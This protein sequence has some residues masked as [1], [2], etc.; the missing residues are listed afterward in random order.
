MLRELLEALEALYVSLSSLNIG[1]PLHWHVLHVSLHRHM[2][3]IH[4]VHI[5]KLT[6]KFWILIILTVILWLLIIG[7]K[8]ETVYVPEDLILADAS[9]LTYSENIIEVFSWNPI[10]KMNFDY[11]EEQL[12][13]QQCIGACLMLNSMPHNFHFVPKFLQREVLKII[14]FID[15]GLYVI[16]IREDVL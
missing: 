10:S 6:L 12:Q 9:F 5:T 13:S 4:F 3:H 7:S 2:L 16:D 15:H 11:P 1:N 8:R 14:K